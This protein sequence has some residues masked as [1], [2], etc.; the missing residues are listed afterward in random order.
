MSRAALIKSC[1]LRLAVTM[2]QQLLLLIQSVMD[3]EVESRRR[4]VDI[5]SDE[6]ERIRR[7]I[8]MI[9]TPAAEIQV[10]ERAN[11]CLIICDVM[12]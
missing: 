7:Y 9:D 6:F 8:A 3:N 2:Q 12:M 1:L 10:R 11:V 4:I 5:C